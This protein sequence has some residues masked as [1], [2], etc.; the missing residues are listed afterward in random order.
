M[1]VWDS[2]SVNKELGKTAKIEEKKTDGIASVS[3][4][5][6][7]QPIAQKIEEED[8]TVIGQGKFGDEFLQQSTRKDRPIVISEY[9]IDELGP[10]YGRKLLIFGG[11]K[12]GKSSFA[13][14]SPEP[15][16]IIDTENGIKPLKSLFKG[17]NIHVFDVIEVDDK[18]FSIDEHRTIE[19]LKL[20]LGHIRHELIKYNT[21]TGLLGTVV[22]DSMTTLW[23]IIMQ[24]L[25]VEVIKMGAIVTA[26]DVPA[27]RRNW[28]K[29]NSL[30]SGIITQLMAMPA[31]V[32]MTAHVKEGSSSDELVDSTVVSGG[33]TIEVPRTQQWVKND[34]DAVIR[35]FKDRSTKKFYGQVWLSRYPEL[36]EGEIIENPSIPNI[37]KRINK[38]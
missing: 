7:Q 8:K 25:N 37:E 4:F 2:D 17:K 30:H 18:T 34:V 21:E 33:E 13:L 5:A 16:Y 6:S 24:W 1:P 31:H 27:D 36:K 22:I 19:K 14:S 23:N 20:T 26:R 32:V 3:K 35:T 28:R 9:T 29:V 38:V 11:A 15:I 12:T 10:R